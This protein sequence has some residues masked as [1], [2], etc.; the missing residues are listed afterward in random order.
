M[1]IV[2]ALTLPANQG[3][4]HSVTV[5]DPANMRGVSQVFYSFAAPKPEHQYIQFFYGNPVEKP[6]QMMGLS[7]YYSTLDQ[8]RAQNAINVIDWK[9][10]TKHL[11]SIYLVCWGDETVFLARPHDALPCNPALATVIKDWRYI[12]RVA[13]FSPAA[14]ALDIRNAM[15]RAMLLL[16]CLT[17]KPVFYMRSNM[18]DRVATGRFRGIIIRSAPLSDWEK[19]VK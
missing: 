15:T 5:R 3:H 16:P 18:A 17:G 6:L 14:R 9:S 11:T 10:K 1:Q 19:R 4:G 8:T 2:D 13:N 12:V 7:Q